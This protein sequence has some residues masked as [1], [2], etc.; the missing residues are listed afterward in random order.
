MMQGG[1][2]RM[3]SPLSCLVLSARGVRVRNYAQHGCVESTN[4]RII[5]G[6]E[7]TLRSSC[8]ILSV[9]AMW[10][11]CVCHGESEPGLVLLP[12]HLW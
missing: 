4:V 9:C 3:I 8:T 12:V 10:M 5:I 7:L 2:P 1:I 6:S 11:I